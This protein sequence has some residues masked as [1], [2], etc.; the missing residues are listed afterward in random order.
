MEEKNNMTSAL[1]IRKE[2]EKKAYEQ[3][4]MGKLE[5]QLRKFYDEMLLSKKVLPEE[6]AE[7][8][9]DIRDKHEKDQMAYID[10]SLKRDKEATEK[11]LFEA[12]SKE[13]EVINSYKKIN[14]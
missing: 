8:V 11:M 10:M 6:F 14:D 13:L 9:Y 7:K 5:R 3:S 12:M 1:T 2:I 4:P